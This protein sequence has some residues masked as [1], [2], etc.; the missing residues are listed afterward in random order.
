[1]APALQDHTGVARAALTG[2]H[3]FGG[4]ELHVG[5]GDFGGVRGTTQLHLFE[6]RVVDPFLHL[7]VSLLDPTEL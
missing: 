2:A 4:N 6:L 1:M 5:H 3:D 7:V